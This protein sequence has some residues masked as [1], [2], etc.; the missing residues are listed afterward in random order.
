[1]AQRRLE[2]A[3]RQVATAS[4][5]SSERYDRSLEHIRRGI[6]VC[7]RLEIFGAGLRDDGSRMCAMSYFIVEVTMVTGPQPR[8]FIWR[9][10]QNRCGAGM[11]DRRQPL[12]ARTLSRKAVHEI[13]VDPPT[14][15]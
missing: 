12:E 10:R 15:G 8:N 14:L 9:L 7:E 3:F 4:D 5:R 11:C 13:C 2:C 1:M 6:R